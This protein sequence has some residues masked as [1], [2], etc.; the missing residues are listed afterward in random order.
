VNVVIAGAN[1]EALDAA[2]DFAQRGWRV[3]V[4]VH[5]KR[6]G[7]GRDIR[8]WLRAADATAAR[9][10]SVLTGVD[11]QC[12]AGVNAVEA[13]LVRYRDTGRLVDVNTSHFLSFEKQPSRVSRKKG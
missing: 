2:I 1:P 12:V 3:L 5:R 9:A 7:L 6:L 11:V 4:V 10:V 13:V 8:R